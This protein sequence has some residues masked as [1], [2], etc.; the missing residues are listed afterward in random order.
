MLA[1]DFRF[2]P[3]LLGAAPHAPSVELPR[4]VKGTDSDAQKEWYKVY[5][6]IRDESTTFDV[7]N[8]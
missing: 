8:D 6:P 2:Q 5:L 1:I 4:C 3:P 7:T